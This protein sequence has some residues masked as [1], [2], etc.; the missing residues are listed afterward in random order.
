MQWTGSVNAV[1]SDSAI[2]ARA[3]RTEGNGPVARSVQARTRSNIA[4]N[5]DLRA[6]DEIGM[7]PPEI[8]RH[9][10]SCKEISY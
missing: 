5:A 10:G 7:A 2:K 8:T 4:S 1:Q 9:G 3:L 6:D